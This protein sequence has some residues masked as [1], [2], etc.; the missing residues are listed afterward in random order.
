MTMVKSNCKNNVASDYEATIR[1]YQQVNCQ[2]ERKTQLALESLNELS[3]VKVMSEIDYSSGYTASAIIAL[4]AL[5]CQISHVYL[6][7][8][9]NISKLFQACLV[10]FYFVSHLYRTHIT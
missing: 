1:H 10:F 7:F 4:V 8:L 2:I 3:H 6:C 9:T 5:Y